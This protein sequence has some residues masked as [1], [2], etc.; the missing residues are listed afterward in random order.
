[1]L[2]TQV[3]KSKKQKNQI[4]TSANL[5]DPLIMLYELKMFYTSKIDKNAENLLR[6]HPK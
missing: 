4:Y 1:M 2:A 6:E 3:T 5:R